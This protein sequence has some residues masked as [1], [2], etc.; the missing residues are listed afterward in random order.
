M[1][2]DAE[3]TLMA[4][5]VKEAELAD[6]YL[7][8]AQ[9]ASARRDSTLKALVV[10]NTFLAIASSGKSVNIPGVG[11]SMS[12]I[13]ALMEVLIGLVSAAFYLSA[14]SFTTWLCY[15]QIHYVF[16]ERVARKK[17]LDPDLYSF[18][19]TS[20]EPTLKMLGPELNIWGPDW[21]AAG[22]GFKV[23]AKLYDICNNLFFL[24][25]PVLHCMLLV[26][27]IMRVISTAEVGVTHIVF[28]AW[29]VLTHLLAV[30]VWVIPHVVFTFIL[31]GESKKNAKA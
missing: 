10:L 11:I 24:M 9:E 26:H 6:K 1:A 30:F 14:H 23:T 17:E 15:S 29:V 25:L 5:P 18:A 28:F 22:K 16:I 4:D 19:E 12:D 8:R 3:L 31:E 21:Y 13:P 27:A 7:A 20:S 2:F